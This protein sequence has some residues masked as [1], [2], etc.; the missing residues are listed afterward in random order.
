MQTEAFLENISIF[1][2]ALKEQDMKDIRAINTENRSFTLSYG[3]WGSGNITDYT[4]EHT[5]VPEE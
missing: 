2:F 5:Y 3:N 1:D 4:Y